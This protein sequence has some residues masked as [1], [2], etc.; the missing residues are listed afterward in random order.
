M[1]SVCKKDRKKLITYNT[2]S[3]DFKAQSLY[4][5]RIRTKMSTIRVQIISVEKKNCI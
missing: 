2:T 5:F 1:L 4:Y 3:D